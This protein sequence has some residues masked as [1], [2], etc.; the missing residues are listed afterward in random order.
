MRRNLEDLRAVNLHWGG[1]RALE[2][3]LDSRLR[4]LP[5]SPDTARILDVG[6]GSGD[7]A[8]RLEQRLR[9]RG[10]RVRVMALDLQWRHLRAGRSIAQ[11]PPPAVAGD[12]FRLP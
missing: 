3:H 1:A 5:S 12:A 11:P 8:A 7:V 2:R 6:A 9:R 4:A 10:H